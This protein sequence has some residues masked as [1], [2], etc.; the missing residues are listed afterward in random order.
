[1]GAIWGGKKGKEFR[2]A[3]N[4]ALQ[5]RAHCGAQPRAGRNPVLIDTP[6]LPLREAER[7][8]EHSLMQEWAVSAAAETSGLGGMKHR[9]MALV[10][11]QLAVQTRK[12]S[13]RAW[14][15]FP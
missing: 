10:V 3:S 7:F 13:H 6:S 2:G 1:M 8:S 11:W 5:P 4:T 14:S 15:P 9:D 12:Q